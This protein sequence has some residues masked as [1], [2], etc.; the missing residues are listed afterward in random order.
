MSG[1]KGFVEITI[2]FSRMSSSAGTQNITNT[3]LTLAD[4]WTKIAKSTI[5]V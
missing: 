5:T 4:L 2:S 3:K 1:R